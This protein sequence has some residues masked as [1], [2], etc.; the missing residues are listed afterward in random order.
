M[1][2]SEFWEIIHQ[3]NSALPKG[4]IFGSSIMTSYVYILFEQKSGNL[5]ISHLDF[6]L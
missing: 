4:L 2:F 3:P 6:D 1:Y 5:Q